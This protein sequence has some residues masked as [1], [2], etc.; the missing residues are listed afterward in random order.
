MFKAEDHLIRLKQTFYDQGEKPGKLLAWQIKKLE[1]DGA[2]NTI[3][4]ENYLRNAVIALILKPGK[5]ATE[6]GSYRPIS[7]LN[8]D[9]KII[10]N[11]LGMRL[12]RVLPAIIHTEQ[13]GFVQKTNRGFTM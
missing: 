2:I 9:T 8:S 4:L 13:N 6:R 5:E 3:Q 7:L 10:A 1:S 11:I 12:E